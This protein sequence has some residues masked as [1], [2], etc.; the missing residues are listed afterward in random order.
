MW[1][2]GIASPPKHS[3]GDIGDRMNMIEMCKKRTGDKAAVPKSDDP[4]EQCLELACKMVTTKK[5]P[6]GRTM[7]SSKWMSFG[8]LTGDNSP[9]GKG[10]VRALEHTF[11]RK[12][13]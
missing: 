3:T 6:D 7:T 13:E 9:C 5:L 12:V 4:N 8:E 1:K 11:L 2:K 10:G